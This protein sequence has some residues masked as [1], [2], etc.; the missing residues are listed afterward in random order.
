MLTIRMAVNSATQSA[1]VQAL[2]S[3]SSGASQP[4]NFIGF[5]EAGET[6]RLPTSHR[7]R[8]PGS[9]RSAWRAAFYEALGIVGDYEAEREENFRFVCGEVAATERDRSATLKTK[10]AV[11]PQFDTPD[12]RDEWDVITATM[13]GGVVW[14]RYGDGKIVT[15]RDGETPQEALTRRERE[16]QRRQ[17]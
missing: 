6:R 12:V 3:C 14:R 17:E 16:R 15:T 10:T 4:Q 7:R 5:V 1:V 13:D 11:T 9:I 8:P 2:T